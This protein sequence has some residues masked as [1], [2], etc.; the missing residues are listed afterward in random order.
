M[1]KIYYLIIFSISII[2]INSSVIFSQ[3]FAVDVD[4]GTPGLQTS[5]I[6]APSTALSFDLTY[7]S[8]GIPSLADAYAIALMYN[9]LPGILS[10]P[11]GPTLAAPGLFSMTP[12]PVNLFTLAAIPAPGVVMTPMAYV[13]GGLGTGGP[14]TATDGGVGVWSVATLFFGG[15]PPPPY[16]EVVLHTT[17]VDAVSIGTTDVAP[18]G[19]FVCP[20]PIGPPLFCSGALPGPPLPPT[21][22]LPIPGGIGPAFPAVAELYA[23]GTGVPIAAP[24][25]L[26][27]PPLPGIMPSTVTVALPLPVEMTSFDAVSEGSTVR[28]FWETISES[29]NSGFEIQHLRKVNGAL[30]IQNWI[31]IGFIEGHGNSAETQHYSHDLEGFR[32]GKH[33]FRIKQLDHDGRFDVSDHVELVV[34]LP[35]S[36]VL[37]QAYPNP[38]NPRATFSLIVKE[39]QDVK[40]TLHDMRGRQVKTLFEG[41]VNANHE[42]RVF[43]DG[44]GLSSGLYAY[45]VEGLS[46]SDVRTVV[47]EK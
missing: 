40:V 25:V 43:I 19:A 5:V 42:H 12:A 35:E 23:S 44:T 33:F 3:A 32:P 31:S 39:S 28:L 6:V 2:F 47:L 10:P 30:P 8:D 13:P 26:G 16:S 38:F 37:S 18:V 46:F 21:A 11:T 17:P 4:A 36:H 24:G 22:L 15:T 20:S 7:I 34:D 41:K 45:R 9:D 14:F 1:R 27:I 29:N